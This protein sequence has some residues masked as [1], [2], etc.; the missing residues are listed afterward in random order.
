MNDDRD[1][2]WRKNR[3]SGAEFK[4]R[5]KYEDFLF[6]INI[7][8]IEENLILFNNSHFLDTHTQTTKLHSVIL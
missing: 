4:E 3:A 8:F 1:M 2:A 6:N 5:L 7:G